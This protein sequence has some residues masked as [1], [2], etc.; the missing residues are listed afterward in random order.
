MRVQ[1]IDLVNS[2]IDITSVDSLSDLDTV[3]DRLLVNRKLHVCFLRK[4]FS[5]ARIAFTDEIVHDDK[6]NVPGRQ[7]V[8]LSLMRCAVRGR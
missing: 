5:S 8:R 2:G 3:L 7:S 1:V 6:I 4:L